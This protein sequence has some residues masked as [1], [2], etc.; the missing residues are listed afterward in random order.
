MHS[1]LLIIFRGRLAWEYPNTQVPRFVRGCAKSDMNPENLKSFER[2]NPE[3][4]RDQRPLL[5]IEFKRG[6]IDSQYQ[7]ISLDLCHGSKTNPMFEARIPQSQAKH[8]VHVDTHRS[9]L[10]GR[11]SDIF[12][13]I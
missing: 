11:R 2:W 7:G 8:F 5:S 3:I 10:V 1:S 4:G 13:D 6:P 9:A 12:N